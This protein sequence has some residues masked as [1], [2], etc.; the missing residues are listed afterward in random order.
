MTMPAEK[1]PT[2]EPVRNSTFADRAAAPREH[3]KQES[4]PRDRRSYTLRAGRDAES[5]DFEVRRVQA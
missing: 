4:T 5:P 2:P 1:P 3:E